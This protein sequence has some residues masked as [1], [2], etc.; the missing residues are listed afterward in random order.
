MNLPKIE[1]LVAALLK[2][3]QTTQP[4]VSVTRVIKLWSGLEVTLED[5][6][7]EGFIL[8]LGRVGGQIMVKR[9]TKFERQR[10]SVA[11]ELGHWQ[12]KDYGIPLNGSTVAARDEEVEKWCNRFASALL[13]PKGWIKQD[14]KDTKG[15]ELVKRIL[16]LTGR[17]KVSRESIFIRIAEVSLYNLMELVKSDT[18]WSSRLY[19]SR[20]LPLRLDRYEKQLHS[21]LDQGRYSGHYVF[22][23]NSQASYTI[24]RKDERLC[25]WLV[26]I[27]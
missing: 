24:I 5:L 15:I 20:L 8:D 16:S 11:H 13:M 23:D 22:D 1:P 6:D 17:Y 18:A 14:L 25:R 12:L 27:A 19:K 3:S 9:N 7:G 4:P 2:R 21:I 26:V 10:Y